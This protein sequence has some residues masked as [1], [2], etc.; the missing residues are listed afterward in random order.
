MIILLYPADYI[1][2]RNY[3]NYIRGVIGYEEIFILY[4]VGCFVFVSCFCGHIGVC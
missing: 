2:N 3:K 1:Q 4:V